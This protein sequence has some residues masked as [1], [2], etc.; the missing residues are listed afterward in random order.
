MKKLAMTLAISLA[1]LHSYADTQALQK[2][3]SADHRTPA[4]TERDEYRNPL[5]TLALFDV[6]PHHTVLEVWPGGGWYTEILA[7]YVKEKGKFIAAH[8]DTSDT[9]AD[10]RPRSRQ[11]FD[12]KMASNKKVYG[13]VD[14][15][16]LMIDEKTKQVVKSPAS[17][18]SVDRIVTFRSAHG[19]YARGISDVMMTELFSL[20]KPG[21]KLGLVQHQAAKN[22]DWLSQNIGYVGRQAIIDSALKAGF[23]LE[24]E[25]YF[26]NNPKDARHHE[27][28]VWQLPPTLRGS[29]SEAE[30]AAYSKIGESHRMTLVFSKPL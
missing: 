26:N 16:S 27:N 30:K 4:Y 8:Y 20:L 12:K 21:G 13:K 7:P 2:A 6:Q 22:Q 24:A 17:E 25:G 11:G 10:Y 23:V 18:N 28:G 19:W 29:A 14:T 15:Q 1:S 3:I 9:Q 5:K